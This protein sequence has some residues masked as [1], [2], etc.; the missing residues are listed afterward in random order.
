MDLQQNTAKRMR[1]KAT[2]PSFR[3]SLLRFIK[4]CIVGMLGMSLFGCSVSI[5]DYRNTS[6]KLDLFQYFDGEVKAWGMLQD[7][8]GKQTR[9][10]EVDIKGT[11]KGKQL[12]LE[13]D[14][15]FDDGEKQRRVWVITEMADGHFIGEADD[16]VGQASGQVMGN[17]LNWRYVLRVPVGDSTYDIHFN[18]WMYLQ[19]DR[20]MFNQ[21]EMTKFGF[22]VGQ[23]TLFFERVSPMKPR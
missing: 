16:V 12:T 19:D 17:A 21:A 4:W 23:V 13:E 15:I 1:G 11:V 10:F 5:D 3:P 7:R 22:K 18:D 14:F 8:S 2:T 9:R 20:R 6:P